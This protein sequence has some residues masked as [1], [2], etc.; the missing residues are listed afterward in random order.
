MSLKKII[1]G[2]LI[3]AV[4]WFIMF[5]PWTKDLFNFWIMMIAATTS[6]NLYSFFIGKHQLKQVYNFNNQ[7]ILVGL[8]SA[9]ILYITF[10]AG[11]YFSNL[12]FNFA[13]KQIENIYA[14]KSQAGKIFIGAALLLWIGPAEEIFWRGFAQH[15]LQQLYG[16]N[17]GFLITSAVYAIV[18]IWAFNFMLF[19]AALICG[20]FWGWMYKKYKSLIPCIISHAVWDCVIFVILPIS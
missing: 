19:M 14:T 3:A 7:F 16:E 17:K 13:G 15:N 11:N 20:L 1:P 4:F 9:A 2:F 8:I 10:F 6:L 12:L 18:H 5:A